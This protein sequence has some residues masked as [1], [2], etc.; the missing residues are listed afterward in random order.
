MGR[1]ALASLVAPLALW[2][3]GCS[4]STP[5]SHEVARATS[6]D[7]ELDAVLIETNAGATA[8]FGYEVHVVKHGAA[9]AGAP[10]A[11]LYGAT[12]NESAYGANLRWQGPRS[13]VVEYLAARSVE[14]HANSVQGGDDRVEIALHDGIAD[15]DAAPGGMHYNLERDRTQPADPERQ[16]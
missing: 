1:S 8:S 12:R 4:M 15:P 13:L 3:G 6:P 10:A 11:R 2:L 5:T 14:R 16:P 9:A 7:A